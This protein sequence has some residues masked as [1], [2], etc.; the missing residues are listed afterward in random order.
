[1][2]LERRA[3]ARPASLCASAPLR[4][5]VVTIIPHSAFR[6]PH[7]AHGG[8]PVPPRRDAIR[9]LRRL[10]RPR[11]SRR[12]DHFYSA[13]NFSHA[14]R[15]PNI[16]PIRPIPPMCPIHVTRHPAPVT[17]EG[18]PAKCAIPI[19]VLGAWNFS[20][21]WWLDAWS[22]ALRILLGRDAK[23]VTRFFPRTTITKCYRGA[24]HCTKTRRVTISNS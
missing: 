2:N 16:H 24:D 7:F 1:M 13:Q 11:R 18:V 6:T 5:R 23:W 19:L 8:V 9:Q 10:R 22:F 21:A 4:L 17:Q 15:F 14:T 20:G 3:P 12:H